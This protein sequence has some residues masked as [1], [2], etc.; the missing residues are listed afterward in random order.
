MIEENIF[1]DLTHEFAKKSPCLSRHFGA[2]LVNSEN[3]II[4]VGYNRPVFAAM[5]C[6][7]CPRKKNQFPSGKGLFMCPAVHAEI[8]CLLL[9]TAKIENSTLYVSGCIPCKS[10][11]SALILSGVSEIVCEELIY[12]DELS[13]EIHQ[14]SDLLIRKYKER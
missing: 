1:R 8:I 2:V 10:C 7:E 3:R 4:S 6:E 11:L 12:Y 13:K 9:A 5:I 14:N